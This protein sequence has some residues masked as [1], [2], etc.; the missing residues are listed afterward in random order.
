MGQQRP[1]NGALTP[2]VGQPLVAPPL[3]LAAV[4]LRA[5]LRPEVAGAVR[6]ALWG[7][8]GKGGGLWAHHWGPPS[9]WAP[10]RPGPVPPTPAA[11][12]GRWDQSRP[13]RGLGVR[14][15]RYHFRRRGEEATAM[16]PRAGVGGFPKPACQPRRGSGELSAGAVPYLRAARAVAP[17]GTHAAGAPIS[18]AGREHWEEPKPHDPATAPSWVSPKA[19]PRP[20]P[21]V[22]V[23]LPDGHCWARGVA[24]EEGAPKSP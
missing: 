9:G 20:A 2:V 22:A 19:P 4:K 24:G 23:E 5:L 6:A 14:R 17:G 18:P 13:G 11:A 16:H 8:G 12:S 1:K 15:R 7:G 3:E 21:S 10:G